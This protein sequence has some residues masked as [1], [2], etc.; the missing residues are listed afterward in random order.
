MPDRPSHVEVVVRLDAGPDSDEEELDRVTEQLRRRMLEL[1]VENAYRPSS[2]DAPEDTRG[3]DAGSM[4]LIVVN[5]LPVLP[6]LYDI[7]QSVR[8]WLA[9]NPE[10]SAALEI[11]GDRLEVSGITLEEQREL[12][13]LWTDRH[14]RG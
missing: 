13:R 4:G 6:A 7:V 10:R 11:D 12:I 2:E 5:L 8:A 1:D 9:H 14:A 3:V